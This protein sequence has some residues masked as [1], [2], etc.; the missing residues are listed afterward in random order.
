MN[1]VDGWIRIILAI[2]SIV[3]SMIIA[4]FISHGSA[5]GSG[6]WLSGSLGASFCLAFLIKC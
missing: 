2:I 1:N 6:C 4:F 5:I 3:A